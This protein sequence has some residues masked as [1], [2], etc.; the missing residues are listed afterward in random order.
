MIVISGALV[1]VALVLLLIG[2]LQPDLAFVYAS[3]AVSLVSFGFLIVGILQRR[4]ET[5]GGEAEGTD[6]VTTPKPSRS[7][8]FGRGKKDS[9]EPAVTTPAA[10]PGKADV[11]T[12]ELAP[13]AAAA[14]VVDEVSGTVLVVAGRPRYHVQGCRY[15]TGKDADEVEVTDAREE[16]FTACGVCKPDVALELARVVPEDVPGTADEIQESEQTQEIDG[17]DD[18]DLEEKDEP[19]AVEVVPSARR[20]TRRAAAPSTL[21]APVVIAEPGVKLVKAPAKRAPTRT[22]A[23]APA[24]VA[25]ATTTPATTTPAKTAPATS[26]P[27][28]TAPTTATPGKAG[29]G[30]APAKKAT[31]VSAAKAAAAAAGVPTPARSAA[32]RGQVVVIPDRGKYHTSECR[33]VRGVDGA[34][35]LS[36]TAATRAG[37]DACGV[38]K[39]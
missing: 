21:P 6:A 15:L 10:V 30:K 2:L 31:T 38:C 24:K 37:Y 3:I 12:T 4:G 5:F 23:K 19:A 22:A 14:D 29:A 17:D 26:A 32:A 9:D 35:V 13:A 34:Q 18:A 7:L 39:P 25:P 33:Y 16:G 36:K 27:T 1:L 20:A 28:R 11:A 8:S